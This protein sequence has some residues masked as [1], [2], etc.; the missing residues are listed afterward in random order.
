MQTSLKS[1]L[2]RKSL[3][4]S[5]SSSSGTNLGNLVTIITKDIRC[6]EQNLW[7]VKDF[8][9]FVLQYV[10]VAYLMWTRIGN[11]AFVGLGLI[12]AA[13]PLQGK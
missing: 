12:C 9:K 5:S 13:L 11:A 7:I 2:Y 8:V 1:L 10:T 3:K 6:V 4:L